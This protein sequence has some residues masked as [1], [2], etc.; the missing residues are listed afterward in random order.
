M[1][2]YNAAENRYECKGAF[3]KALF[4]SAEKLPW[5]VKSPDYWNR[6][7]ER[8]HELEPDE[9]VHLTSKGTRSFLIW[10]QRNF[11]IHPQQTL[12]Y[13]EKSN[14]R[15]GI[16]KDL[17]ALKFIYKKDR[18]RRISRSCIGETTTHSTLG[19]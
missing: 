14:I 18:G 5:E 19:P 13:F 16:R 4:T 11:A 8:L 7:S 10:E 12:R 1:I 2:Q 6:I 17:Q 3:F 15:C 9:P